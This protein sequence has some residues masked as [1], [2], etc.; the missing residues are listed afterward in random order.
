MCPVGLA[1][2]VAS[3]TRRASC[4][5]T[6]DGGKISPWCVH[7]PPSVAIFSRDASLG[8]H[9]WQFFVVVRPRAAIRGNFL[10]SCIPKVV[11]DGKSAPSWQHIAAVYPKRAGFGKICAP[12]IRKAPQIAFWECTARR[13]CREGSLFAALAPRIIHGALIMPGSPP[14]HGPLESRQGVPPDC[15]DPS[16][17]ASCADLA[18]LWQSLPFGGEVPSPE[19]W[20]IPLPLLR[21][22][23]SEHPCLVG[24]PFVPFGIRNPRASW[25]AA[26][27]SSGE[28]EAEK[29]QT[30]I[31]MCCILVW[32]GSRL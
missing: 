10:A 24:R 9:P 26:S 6:S 29:D 16:S 7:G 31:A 13:S 20:G 2:R 18:I 19:G 28:V 30:L 32:Q 27:L 15:I 25:S 1:R 12:C 3:R 11:P 8:G 17:H 22:C 21:W 14:L 4:S 23:E 5:P